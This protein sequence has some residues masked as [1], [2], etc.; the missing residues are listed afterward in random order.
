DMFQNFMDY[1][2]DA[3]MNLFTFNQKERAVIVLQNSPNRKELLTSTVIKPHYAPSHLVLTENQSSGY[4]LVWQDNSLNETK[5]IIERSS[6]KN[7]GYAKIG[8]TST[9]VNT[10]YDNP[11]NAV[12]YYRIIAEN[13]SGKSE[14]ST[15]QSTP[16]LS[17]PV[18][19]SNLSA[20]TISQDEIKLSWDLSDLNATG[21]EIE[22][23]EGNNSNFEKILIETIPSSQKSFSVNSLKDNEVYFFRIK[24]GNGSGSSPYSNET[25]TATFPY[26]PEGPENLQV[27]FDKISRHFYLSWNDKSDKEERFIVERSIDS[28]ENFEEVDIIEENEVDFLDETFSPP[29]LSVFYYRV[30]AQNIGGNS[31]YS[32]IAKFDAVTGIDNNSEINDLELIVYPN[33]VSDIVHLNWENLEKYK[34]FFIEVTDITGKSFL[35]LELSI[36]ESQIKVPINLSGIPNGLYIINIS[37]PIWK[38]SK[39]I[40]IQN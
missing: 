37:N 19:P 38:I 11:G 26:Q 21:V 27:I 39:K 20:T 6:T 23:S 40:I 13:Q 14:Y 12:Y 32:N 18:A 25:S 17:L 31:P 7:S 28:L 5:F 3:C 30:K 34:Q 15:I 24:A 1:T 8:E 22:I 35:R 9:N 10:Y 33:P 36:L 2:A 29:P 16:N 4:D